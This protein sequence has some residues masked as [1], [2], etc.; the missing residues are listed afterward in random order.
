MR[1]LTLDLA[2]DASNRYLLSMAGSPYKMIVRSEE[3]ERLSQHMPVKVPPDL[4]KQLATPMPGK[5][6]SIAV[7]GL[8]LEPAPY[9]QDG[10]AGAMCCSWCKLVRLGRVS[11]RLRWLKI[12]A[13]W[14]RGTS[15][16][17]ARRCVWL[18]L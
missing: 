18:K 14:Q 12:V 10:S 4:S 16:W 7:K 1:G 8:S 15:L 13:L 11:C 3:L 5:L 17:L 9:M 6:H 2:L